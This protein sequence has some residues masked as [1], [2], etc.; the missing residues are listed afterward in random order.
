MRSNLVP[1][2]YTRILARRLALTDSELF[3]AL[4]STELTIDDIYGDNLYITLEDQ[5]T[6]IENVVNLSSVDCAGLTMGSTLDLSNHGLIGIAALS[7]NTLLDALLTL[8]KFYVIRAP[9]LAFTTTK[10]S[11]EFVIKVKSQGNCN[12]VVNRF[13]LE[14]VLAMFQAVSEQILGEVL[15]DGSITFSFFAHKPSAQY[16]AVFHCP[17]TFVEQ[18]Y[19]EYHI[20]LSRVNVSNLTKDK[21]IK[22]QAE[23]EC[24]KALSKLKNEERL[25]A[26][27]IEILHRENERTLNLQQ[28]SQLLNLSPRSL[29]R[30]L[31]QENTSFQTLLDEKNKQLSVEYLKNRNLSIESIA[32]ILGYEYVANFRRAFRRWFNITPS[33]FRKQLLLSEN[34]SKSNPRNFE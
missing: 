26:K 19:C 20:P 25:S 32:S 33:K 23:L 29:I 31:K 5:F 16:H 12:A 10:N 3:N 13:L 30:K 4:E 24:G 7:S 8:T 17:V 28:I 6:I 27:V 22:E 21:V 1:V 11:S 14:A 34:S 18:E 15:T 2:V 9:F